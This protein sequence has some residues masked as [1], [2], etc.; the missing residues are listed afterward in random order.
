[1]S[2]GKQPQPL[3]LYSVTLVL[4]IVFFLGLSAL[5]ALVGLAERLPAKQ[6]A[7]RIAPARA[8]SSMARLLLLKLAK[9]FTTYFLLLALPFLPFLLSARSIFLSRVRKMSSM[10]PRRIL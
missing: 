6:S 1:M 4:C 5:P 8:R 7:R 2:R 10:N 3:T 9:A